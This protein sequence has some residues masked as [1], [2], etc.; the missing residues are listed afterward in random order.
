[1]SS[2]EELEVA[3]R[4]ALSAIQT[5]LGQ[6]LD[7]LTEEY[8]GINN[9]PHLKEESNPKNAEHSA[10]I[11]LVQTLEVD[12]ETLSIEKRQYVNTLK[13][14]NEQLEQYV[15]RGRDTQEETDEIPT[16]QAIESLKRRGIEQGKAIS[17]ESKRIYIGLKE[18][19][20]ELS[21]GDYLHSIELRGE[22]EKL[23]E[24]LQKSEC[25][26]GQFVYK[27]SKTRDN[28]EERIL[29]ESSDPVTHMGG[30]FFSKTPLPVDCSTPLFRRTRLESKGKE[31]QKA[32]VEEPKRM[33]SVLDSVS[34][35]ALLANKVDI[36]S[37]P[38]FGENP[39]DDVV[40]FITKLDISLSF[41]Q[42][43]DKQ[44]ARVV[45]L[46]LMKRAY[47]FYFTLPSIV[48]D[49]YK[50]LTKSLRKEF[51]APELK[52]RK[53]QELHGIKQNGDTITRYLERVE[54]LSQ[55]LQVADQTKLDIMI[56]G[57]DIPYRNYI[58]MKQPRTYSDATHALLLK[59][60]VNPPI[61]DTATM[62]SI[63]AAV[64]AM[65]PSANNRNSERPP[66]V[67][68]YCNRRGNMMRECQLRKRDQSR[69]NRPPTKGP[70]QEKCTQCYRWGHIAKECRNRKKVVD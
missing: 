11:K 49:N 43:D 1:M 59:E 67:C 34:V 36:S 27:I 62:N 25:I 32:Q 44:K 54:R 55:N 48:K 41:Y 37:L 51:D 6:G 16:L 8:R 3:Q 29:L 9:R 70:S 38:K 28:L 69:N 31:D 4:N 5:H 21:S 23:L 56:A 35:A 14:V 22:I 58:Q 10:I 2:Y 61:D 52:Y 68:Y 13:D 30:L 12:I 24:T 26:L 19:E 57:L 50:E 45:P 7:P 18:V 17:E 33:D 15:R 39:S 20:E 40:E 64:E 42:L 65:R 46:L 60:S 53:R 66:M 63:L 47:T